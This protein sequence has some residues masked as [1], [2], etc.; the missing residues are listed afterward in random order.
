MAR[1][2]KQDLESA[3]E[4]AALEKTRASELVKRLEDSHLIEDFREQFI[5]RGFLMPLYSFGST[6]YQTRI[7][8]FGKYILPETMYGELLSGED[9]NRTWIRNE[10]TAFWWYMTLGQEILGVDE[11][12]NDFMKIEGQPA[13]SVWRAIDVITT[14]M[15]LS[16]EKGGGALLNPDHIDTEKMI[17]IVGN[18]GRQ[19]GEEGWLE[20]YSK[21]G[22]PRW[23][24]LFREYQRYSSTIC[25]ETRPAWFHILNYALYD[26]PIQRIPVFSALYTPK[27]QIEG[28]RFLDGRLSHH[29]RASLSNSLNKATLL[30]NEIVSEE[31]LQRNMRNMVYWLWHNVG[32]SRWR[33]KSSYAQIGVLENVPRQTIRSNVRRMDEKLKKGDFRLIWDLM[34]VG[35]KIGLGSDMVYQSLVQQGYVPPGEI[36]SFSSENEIKRKMAVFKSRF[37]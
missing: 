10:D 22:N 5:V 15:D 27:R 29:A 28:I 4:I 6:S 24:S 35:E 2:N 9:E 11:N 33:E 37:K 18:I 17:A 16:G 21:P 36:D 20:N 1:T 32:Y 19:E 3:Y 12:T 30:I 26:L 31:L 8:S 23:V 34:G 25:L 13:V 14:Q 7:S